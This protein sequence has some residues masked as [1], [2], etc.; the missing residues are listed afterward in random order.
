MNR[1]NDVSFGTLPPE[2]GTVQLRCDEG[3][4][5]ARLMAAA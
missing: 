2:R 1:T 5:G 3:F 4:I